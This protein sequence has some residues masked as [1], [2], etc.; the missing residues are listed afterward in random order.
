MVYGRAIGWIDYGSENS[1]IWIVIIE[2]GEVWLAKTEEIRIPPNF[3][4]DYK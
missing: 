3:T 2:G 1:L 4:M